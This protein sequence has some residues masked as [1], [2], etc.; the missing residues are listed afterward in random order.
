MP[1]V[2]PRGHTVDIPGIPSQQ[3]LF[4]INFQ[5]F[6]DN[7]K[8]CLPPEHLLKNKTTSVIFHSAGAINHNPNFSV[9]IIDGRGHNML[10]LSIFLVVSE[11]TNLQMNLCHF[12]VD[13]S[14]Y[15]SFYWT[16]SIVHADA[17]FLLLDS[18]I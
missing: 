13:V 16:C 18:R 8:I 11:Q 2:R 14:L 1:P 10:Y 9:E 17:I 7:V 12:P 5:Y 15:L 4:L 3:P 6:P